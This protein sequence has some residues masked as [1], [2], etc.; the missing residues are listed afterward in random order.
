MSA[1]KATLQLEPSPPDVPP[2]R[3]AAKL[4]EVM[5][6]VGYVEKRGVNDFHRYKYATEADVS[7]AVRG[8]LAKRGIIMVPSLLEHAEREM[9]T[10]KGQTEYVTRVVMEYT[11]HDGETGETLSFKMPGAGQDRGDKGI[12]KAISGSEK[13]A[14]KTLFLIPTGDDPEADTD[15]DKR[16]EEPATITDEQFLAL[17]DLIDATNTETGAFCTFF[18]IKALS[19]LPAAQYQRALGSLNAKLAKMQKGA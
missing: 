1:T 8:E 5:A 2:K 11:L 17:Q 19:D 15:T 9:T 6:A 16:N 4:A 3:L 10:Q 12:Y 18:K 14:L 13:Y 7:A